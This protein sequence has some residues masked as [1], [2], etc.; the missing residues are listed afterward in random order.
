MEMKNAFALSTSFLSRFMTHNST[1]FLPSGARLIWCY[2]CGQNIYVKHELRFKI[3]IA[4]GMRCSDA[5]HPFNG[6][7]LSAKAELK[8][9]GS[10]DWVKKHVLS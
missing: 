8:D 10:P 3:E 1:R 9:A 7:F 5:F 6:Q 2:V 4:Q